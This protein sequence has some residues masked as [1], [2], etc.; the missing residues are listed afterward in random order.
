MGDGHRA[1]DVSRMASVP[2]NQHDSQRILRG[3]RLQHP[4]AI[5]IIEGAIAIPLQAGDR[6]RV[7]S[8]SG[9]LL[10]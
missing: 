5:L 10:S 1:L 8:F 7:V 6:H 4:F 9:L 3:E 2:R